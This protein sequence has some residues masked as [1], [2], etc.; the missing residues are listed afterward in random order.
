MKKLLIASLILAIASCSTMKET[1]WTDTAIDV[2]DHQYKKMAELA[3]SQ[4]AFPRTVTPGDSIH[5]VGPQ[6]WTSGF[7]PGS[8]FFLHDLTE[9]AEFKSLGLRLTDPL[10]I[11]EYD[12]STH[13]LGF[14]IYCSYGNAFRITEDESYARL[15]LNGANSLSSR[16][17]S[18]TG[19]IRSWDWGPW[20][21][22]VI[23]DNMMNLE[24]LFWAS[25][26]SG[27]ERYRTIAVDHANTTMENHF[28]QDQ[29]SYHVVDYD[30]LTGEAISKATFQGYSDSSAWSRG[31]A[32][33][34]YGYTMSYRETKDEKY[35]DHAEK[36]A[37][38]ILNHPNL[39]EDNVPYWDFD[40]PNIPDEPRDASAAALIA[41]ALLELS[42]YSEKGEEYFTAAEQILMS[43]SSPEYLAEKGDNNYFILKHSTGFKPNNSEVDVPLNYADY[44]YLEA[45][46]RYLQLQKS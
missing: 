9:D 33:G 16:Y 24:F 2:A 41:S 38:F 6:D 40:A 28:R 37:N 46:K 26:Y 39:P 13:D 1:S 11:L 31:Q 17:D 19:C 36:I 25:R 27:D 32:W 20:Q 14:M 30:T 44:Y 45:L 29:S 18:I 10:Q 7:F 3:L 42:E 15:M 43:L 5:W 4:E 12:S 22:P 35:L 34:L 21:F 23:I 8:L